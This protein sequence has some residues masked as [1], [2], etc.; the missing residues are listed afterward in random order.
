MQFVQKKAI[1]KICRHISASSLISK[2]F[3]YMCHTMTSSL[4][5]RLVQDPESV[6]PGVD[7]LAHGQQRGVAV[8]HPGHLK[9][10]KKMIRIKLGPALFFCLQDGQPR[11]FF[12]SPLSAD[13]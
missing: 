7:E 1:D 3:V 13:D 11:N 9:K 10:E 6:V 4:L 2:P 12:S 5:T 8:A